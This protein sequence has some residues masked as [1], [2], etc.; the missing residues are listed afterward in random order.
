[1]NPIPAGGGHVQCLLHAVA[2]EA[3]WKLARREEARV[4]AQS[5]IAA[6]PTDDRRSELNEQLSYILRS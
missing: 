2:A 3:L 5:A 1:V 6:C 4:S